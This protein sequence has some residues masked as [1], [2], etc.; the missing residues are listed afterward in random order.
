VIRGRGGGGLQREGGHINFL[1]LK[2]EGG[3][4]KRN[5]RK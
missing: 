3:K 4:K 5:K 2:R 1:S